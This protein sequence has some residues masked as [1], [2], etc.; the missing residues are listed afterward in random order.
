M[1]IGRLLI[2]VHFGSN[3]ENFDISIGYLNKDG[4][5][6]GL[7][8]VHPLYGVEI[9][10]PK[11]AY[12]KVADLSTT[13][14]SGFGANYLFDVEMLRFSDTTKWIGSALR[15]DAQDD[16]HD[17]I[18]LDSYS[19]APEFFDAQ[20]NETVLSGFN[21]QD[22]SSGDYAAIRFEMRQ[23]TLS[24]KY[25]FGLDQLQSDVAGNNWDYDQV[26]IRD[27]SWNFNVTPTKFVRNADKSLVMDTSIAVREF[28]GSEALEDGQAFIE[29]S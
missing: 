19:L 5:I 25:F 2:P 16:R 28:D 7:S 4:K 10:S 26:R 1:I 11:E 15:Y 29:V 12:V 14:S 24:D 8:A 9:G 18:R 21:K 17:Q 23:D 3:S 13:S 20:T 22:L 27:N 6:S